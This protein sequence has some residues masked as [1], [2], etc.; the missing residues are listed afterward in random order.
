MHSARVVH[1]AAHSGIMF[2]MPTPI[3]IIGR[4][5][6]DLIVVEFVGYKK[7]GTRKRRLFRC[8]CDCG[9]ETFQIY[10]ALTGGNARSCGCKRN[11]KTH[12]ESGS[13]VYSVWRA[14]RD[15]CQNPSDAR[16]KWYGARGVKVCARWQ[17]YVTFRNDMG[18]RP[19][20]ATLE[21]GNPAGNYEPSNCRW[22]T[23][24]EQANNKRGTK[25]IV[26]QSEALTLSQWARRLGLPLARLQWRFRAGW[27]VAEAFTNGW[28]RGERR[29][30]RRR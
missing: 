28:S 24:I 4:R 20:G 11:P 29:D 25:L 16:F 17:D 9:G 18:P 1:G 27:P 26:F 15:R 12:G 13:P 19:A 10:G 22:A 30:L 8:R 23:Y 6:G 5:F 7:V 3:E 21:R 14:M 2:R